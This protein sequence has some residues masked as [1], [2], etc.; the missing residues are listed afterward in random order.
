MCILY[1]W[2]ILEPQVEQHTTLTP[3]A[4]SFQGFE[5]LV[6]GATHTL[7]HL[8]KGFRLLDLRWLGWTIRSIPFTIFTDCLTQDSF[9]FWEHKLTQATAKRGAIINKNWHITKNSRIQ[10]PHWSVE[11]TMTLHNPIVPQ[12]WA[13]LPVV[14]PSRSFRFEAPCEILYTDVEGAKIVKCV[15]DI[16]KDSLRQHQHS[17]PSK[18]MRLHLISYLAWWS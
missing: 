13:T 2:Q 11:F 17:Q 9:L 6:P 12:R 14:L 15:E 4:V 5:T 1:L 7:H 3:S 10:H 8:I 16:F 18:A